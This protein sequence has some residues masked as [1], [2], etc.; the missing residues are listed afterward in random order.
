LSAEEFAA[1]LVRVCPR[2]V[3]EPNAQA[4]AAELITMTAEPP[5]RR[6]G[7]VALTKAFEVLWQRGWQP[8]DIWQ[9]VRRRVDD[10]AAE[11]V[12]GAIA[13]QSAEYPGPTL[14]PRW[15]AQ[16]AE[17]GATPWWSPDQSHLDGYAA[18]H[19]LD[20]A[21]L[22]ALL[23]RVLAQLSA[24]PVLPI[25]VAPPG[26][27]RGS[28]A[29]QPAGGSAPG[30]PGLSEGVDPKVLA[31][32]RGLLAKAEST[33]FP[34]E[35]DAFFA[36]AQEL[37]SRY[38]LE[39]AVV[40]ALGDRSG[41]VRIQ[42]GGRRIWLDNPYLSPKSMLVNAVASANRCQAVFLAQLGFVTVVGEE[43]DTEIVE[44]LTTSLL[45]QAGRAM[46]GAGSRVDRYGQS[47][48]KSFRQSF[49]VSYAQRIGERLTEA[50]EH[51]QSD[52]VASIGDGR[53]L[54]VLAAREQAV[55]ERMAE[56]FP[57]V[58]T[59][60]VSISNSAGWTAGR[61]AADLANLDIRRAV[62]H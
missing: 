34:E 28:P 31:K 17:I 19:R 46:L 5:V 60:S 41:P 9:V 42:T 45:V 3:D 15:R 25:L 43:T 51:A 11:L 44:L 30:A 50:G 21:A 58:T 55:Q 56:Y 61:A 12:V 62:G 39:R 54:P 38:S 6:S 57:H 23:L 13:E 1:M 4:L 18:R 47:R 16:L 49:L 24:L 53:L 20:D 26:S 29:G 37:M 32:V 59:R 35:A 14:H 7:G 22:L 27:Y 10:G 52:L 40:E 2:A 33:D 36:K 8:V 48:T